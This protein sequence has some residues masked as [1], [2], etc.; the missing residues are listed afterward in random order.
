MASY[1]KLLL[2]IVVIMAVVM[3][4]VIKGPS[5]KPIMS[6]GDWL[7]S[8]IDVG[9]TA[10]QIKSLG[11]SLEHSAKQTIGAVIA[12]GGVDGGVTDD[13]MTQMDV[14]PADDKAIVP[15]ASNQMYKWRDKNGN[16]QFSNQKPTGI[17]N[18]QVENLPEVKNV[19]NATVTS[20][21]NSSTI[22]LPEGLSLENAG[23]LLKKVG[24]TDE[25]QK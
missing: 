4:M 21:K 6:P 12:D 3:P 15:L 5:G 19:M 13:G 8:D 23:E 22:G 17:T 9:N 25:Q 2:F 20:R 1:T 11:Q 14:E 24:L 18:V 10:R 7:P 16:W